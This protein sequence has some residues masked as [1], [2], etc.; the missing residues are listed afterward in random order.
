MAQLLTGGT[1][2]V[3]TA[4]AAVLTAPRTFDIQDLEIP[5]PGAD[6]GLMRIEACGIC[7]ADVPVWRGETSFELP[8]VLGHEIVGRAEQVGPDAARRWQIDNGDRIIVERWIPCG[9]CTNCLAGNY[10]LCVREIDGHRLFYG[11][12]PTM[13][14]PS[15]YGGYAEYLY[16]HPNS[17]VY[18][19]SPDVPASVVPLFTPLGNAISWIQKVGG[20]GMGD[21]IVIQGPGQE[22]L[23]AVVVAK[24]SGAAQ[25]IVTGL[26]QDAA[27]LEMAKELGATAVIN[28]EEADQVDVVRRLTRGEMANVV[29][30]LTSSPDLRPL[31][32][33]MEMA[34]TGATIVLPS[35]HAERGLRFD[36]ERF[37]NK[38]LT[39]RGAWGRDRSSVFAAIAMIESGR[40]GLDR[41]STHHF[42]L[43]EIDLALRTVAREANPDALH[44]SIVF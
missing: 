7:A 8:V 23:A 40:F 6:A 22:G 18:K 42:G 17:V 28:V 10:R 3:S 25:I 30:E 24:A 39:L 32:A 35:L 29:L 27:R 34:G 19:V 38:M 36:S 11:G 5:A 21:T 4:R 31:E 2:N 41:L 16:L 1:D 14:A 9:H 43:D 13:L 12:A 33:A 44:A 15:L 20:A 26:A 37:A